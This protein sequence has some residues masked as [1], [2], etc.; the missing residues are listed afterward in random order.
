MLVFKQRQD[1]SEL[2]VDPLRDPGLNA[3]VIGPQT[4]DLKEKGHHFLYLVLLRCL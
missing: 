1:F 2:K 4:K 3:Q